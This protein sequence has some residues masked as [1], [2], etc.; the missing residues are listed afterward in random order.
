[1]V[2]WG[3]AEHS[4]RTTLSGI[5]FPH[6]G[7]SSTALRDVLAAQSARRKVRPLSPAVVGS[8]GRKKH[9]GGR[10]Q[11]NSAPLF[12]TRRE[13][14]VFT[15]AHLRK[16]VGPESNQRAAKQ[17]LQAEIVYIAAR[18]ANDRLIR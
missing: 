14:S 12:T 9:S 17:S 16:V 5:D 15:C 11:N 13:G 4:R 7:M 8:G 3:L 6:P 18:N 1:M 10:H 2:F